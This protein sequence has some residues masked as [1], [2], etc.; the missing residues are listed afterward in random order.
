MDKVNSKIEVAKVLNEDFA[1]I[2]M[3]GYDLPLVLTSVQMNGILN[4][5]CATYGFE[6]GSL[7]TNALKG[8]AITVEVEK[9]KAGDTKVLTAEHVLVEKGVSGKA[10][11]ITR[12][13]KQ[14]TLEKG[15]KAKVGDIVTY[16]RDKLVIGSL[17]D[18]ILDDAQVE[19]DLRFASARVAQRQKRADA[20]LDIA[21][22]G[23]ED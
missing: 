6:A 18:V 23:L 7:S 3:A 15:D 9:Q 1:A 4:G 12:G 17:V 19:R 16:Q 11:T 10:L 14:V 5:Q 20:V 21:N 2:V 13:D 8:A 22:M